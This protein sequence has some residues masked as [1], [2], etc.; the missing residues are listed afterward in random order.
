MY[1]SGTI[2][3]FNLGESVNILPSIAL[4][5]KNNYLICEYDVKSLRAFSLI[6]SLLVLDASSVTYT[7]MQAD[8]LFWD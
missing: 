4:N 3:L 7:I 5:S 2:I 8:R 1:N 6:S